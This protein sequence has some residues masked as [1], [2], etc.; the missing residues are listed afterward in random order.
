MSSLSSRAVKSLGK[1]TRYAIEMKRCM[2]ASFTN[3]YVFSPVFIES[4][5]TGGLCE[6]PGHKP[7]FDV[8][9]DNAASCFGTLTVNRN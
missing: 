9:L 1:V 6:T 7:S 3:S 2:Y 8:Q 5:G 4:S